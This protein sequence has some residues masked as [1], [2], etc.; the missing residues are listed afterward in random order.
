M[1][2][3][4]LEKDRKM[5]SHDDIIETFLGKFVFLT[6]VKF[7]EFKGLIEGMA[8]LT[9]DR[10]YEDIDKG[11]YDKFDDKDKYGTVYGYDLRHLKDISN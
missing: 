6:N 4:I 2:D 10:A 3:F 1:V 7:T 11:V 8:V 5:Y 9:A